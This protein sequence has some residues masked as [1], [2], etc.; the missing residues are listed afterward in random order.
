LTDAELNRV[1][2]HAVLGHG[3]AVQAIRARGR[4]GT[5]VGFA[6]VPLVA[7]PPIDTPENVKAAEIAT[8]ELNAPF[9]SV[10]LEGRYTEPTSRTPAAL[11]RNSRRRS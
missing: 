11:R 8:R 3:R 10:M 7:I 4:P 2:H 6:E 9:L 5:K 1:R